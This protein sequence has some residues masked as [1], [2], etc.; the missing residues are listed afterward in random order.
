M[1][2][3][4]GGEGF[5]RSLEGGPSDSRTKGGRGEEASLGVGEPS[6]TGRGRNE[7]T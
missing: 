1:K 5:V 7:A 6:E 3:I 2:E 4:H